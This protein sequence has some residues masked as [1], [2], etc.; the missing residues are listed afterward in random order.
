MLVVFALATLGVV[1]I[2]I[3]LA[4]GQWWVLAPALLAHLIASAVAVGYIGARL[5]QEDKPD[6]I[7]EARLRDEPRADARTSS[8]D[9]RDEP[10]M[11]I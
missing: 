3:A 1:G 9:D 7:T 5:G 2:V 6:P 8:P 11:A 4:T 10:H